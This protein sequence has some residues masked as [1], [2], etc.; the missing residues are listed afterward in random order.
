MNDVME[1]TRFPNIIPTKGTNIIFFTFNFFN[2]VINIKDPS[3]AKINEKTAFDITPA[4]GINNIANINPILAESIVPAVVGDVN[5]F[6][7]ICC[8]IRPLILSPIPAITMLI[9]LGTLLIKIICI[10]LLSPANISLILILLTPINREI[11][12][13][14]TKA[15]AKYLFFIL[16]SATY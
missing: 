16:S 12:D 10:L 7:L 5:L 3:N 13:S 15:I 9:S 2:I 8:I 4:F 11:S 1:L 14:I 6:L